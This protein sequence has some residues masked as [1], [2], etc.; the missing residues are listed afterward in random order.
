MVFFFK[1]FTIGKGNYSRIFSF[2]AIL[3][4]NFPQ[5]NQ[6][7]KKVIKP[8]TTFCLIFT[9]AIFTLNH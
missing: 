8:K 6:Q 3:E 7:N 5:L 2:D 1:C 4:I 9:T